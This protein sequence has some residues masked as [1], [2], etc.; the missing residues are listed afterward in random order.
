MFK[1]AVSGI[2]GAIVGTV[3]GGTVVG[4]Q[5]EKHYAF[6]EKNTSKYTE[7][8]NVLYQWLRVYQEGKNLSRYFKNHNYRKAVVYGMSEVGYLVVDELEKNGIDVP[9]CIDKNADNFF[10]KMKIYRPE[11]DLPETDVVIVAA[12]QYY[13]DIKACLEKK[14]CCPIVSLADIVW[15]A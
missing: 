2:I 14:M 15:E 12:V 8:Y 5:Y 7:L 9:Y 6:V 10:A 11:D 3:V 1:K 13:N 4:K